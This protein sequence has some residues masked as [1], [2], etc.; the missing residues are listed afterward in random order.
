[1]SS[2]EPRI[3][4]E[5]G[6]NYVQKRIKKLLN[7]LEGLP[8]THLSSED[9]IMIY[10]NIYNICTRDCSKQVYDKYKEVIYDYIRSTVLPSLQGKKDE[11]LLRELLK[12]WSNH[13]TMTN[14]LS[15]FFLYLETYYL[16][17]NSLQETSFLS[18]Y[19]LV[20]DKLNRQVMDTILAM[21]DR[22]LVGETIDE[23]LFN[24]M[25]VFYLEI[26]EK[27]R[28][29]EPKHCAKTMMKAN[30]TFYMHVEASD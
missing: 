6:W 28:K 18:F 16:P 10:T 11:L 20:Y 5:E 26:G 12:R 9:N 17:K 7:N 8:D 22:K 4:F 27:T 3:D 25:L 1:M 23:T 24:N 15:K 19:D 29:E 2:F 21:I 30:G 13:K 14:R